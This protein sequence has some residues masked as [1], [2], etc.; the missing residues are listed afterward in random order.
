M[1]LAS[2]TMLFAACSQENLLS[3][4]E[5]LAQTPENNAI[6]FGTYLGKTGTRAGAGGSITNDGAGDTHQLGST[7][8]EIGVFAY[9]TGT[10]T[11][12]QHQRSTY[13]AETD[14]SSNP[15]W[16]TAKYPNF[17]YNQKVA[18]NSTNWEYSPLKYWPND[19]AST[20]VDD[21]GAVGSTSHGGNVSFFAYAPYVATASGTDG[22]TAMTDN[23]EP[24][25]PKI[26]Y[27]LESDVDLLWGTAGTYS[28]D[29]ALSTGTNSG[30]TGSS[31]AA[32]NTYAKA[33][34]DGYTVNADLTK[35]KVDKQVNFV[36]KHALAA[37]GGGSTAGPGTGFRVQLDIDNSSKGEA[38]TAETGGER[39]TFE[40][41]T[42]WRTK[43]TIKSIK[44]TNDLN[45]DGD[46]ADSGEGEVALNRTGVLNLATGAWEGSDAGKVEQNVL[47]ASTYNAT[48]IQ[49][50]SKIAEMK[51]DAPSTTKF[52]DYSTK[53]DY[54]AKSL[55]STLPG[56]TTTPQDV[57]NSTTQ[58][59][60]MLIPGQAPTFKITVEYVVRQ[61]DE[62]LFDKYTEVTNT[63]SKTVTF[64]TIEMNKYYSLLMHLGLT[65]VKFTATV[66][67]WTAATIGDGDG[68][69]TADNDV[70][71]PIN[72]K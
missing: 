32:D 46:A 40:T 59:P 23:N 62:A 68:D 8:Y 9:Y 22:I 47:V 69:T 30:V 16:I 49:L 1:A 39:E 11:Y 18:L 24:G 31:S 34:K 53:K 38:A 54:F 4:Q 27:K 66:S 55:D 6:Q 2:A 58:T 51:T 70:Y 15:G 48:N 64:P 17:M 10:A 72:V 33:I 61:Y 20:A 3:P 26:T 42:Y 71:L 63:I 19:F 25:D 43:V 56:V 35:Q 29:K 45:G 65:S 14:M 52:S 21:L 7:G 50:N 13:S 67:N 37:V 36:F 28:D 60:L 41:D 5:Q 12:G 57:Y 44:I